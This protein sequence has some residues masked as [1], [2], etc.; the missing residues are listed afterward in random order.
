[1]LLFVDHLFGL[2]GCDYHLSRGTGHQEG[3]TDLGKDRHQAPP[4]AN[5]S[6]NRQRSSLPLNMLE[7]ARTSLEA[8]EVL[9]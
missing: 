5:R 8:F 3:A 7:F 1:V 9:P 4:V 2:Y 6:G